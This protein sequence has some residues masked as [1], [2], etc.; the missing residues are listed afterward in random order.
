MRLFILYMRLTYTSPFKVIETA[1]AK[2][3]A[4]TP[5]S[6]IRLAYVVEESKKPFSMFRNRPQAHVLEIDESPALVA[7]WF[8]DKPRR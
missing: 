7:E 4:D 3:G 5:K 8:T 1:L 6:Q 2:F